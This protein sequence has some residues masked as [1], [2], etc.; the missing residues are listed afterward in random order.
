MIWSAIRA[1]MERQ[2]IKSIAEL[3]QRTGINPST[4]QHTRRSNPHSFII[5]EL[6]QIDRVLH[7]T[8]AEWEMI[9]NVE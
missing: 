1:G 4:L 6:L 5:Y 9:R 3:A 8:P 2:K 7:F